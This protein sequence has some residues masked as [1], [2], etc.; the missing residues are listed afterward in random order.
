MGRVRDFSLPSP[1]PVTR[2]PAENHTRHSEIFRTHGHP[3]MR[4]EEL[5][6]PLAPSL[7]LAHSGAG[8]GRGSTQTSFRVLHVLLCAFQLICSLSVSLAISERVKMPWL[9]LF[10]S[11]NPSKGTVF[12]TRITRGYTYGF[13]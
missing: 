2:P 13:E 6:L 8:R 10:S 1:P 4:A 7:C 5:D 11:L 12:A 3:K 9:P